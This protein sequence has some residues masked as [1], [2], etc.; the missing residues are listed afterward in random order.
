MKEGTFKKNSLQLNYVEGPNNGSPILLLHGAT[1]RWQSYE[2]IIDELISHFHLFLMDFRGHG[3]SQ[4]VHGKYTLEHYVE[5]TKYFIKNHIKKPTILVGH[6]LGG[7]VSI[8]LAALHPELVKALI[9]IDAPLTLHSLRGL[10]SNLKAHANQLIQ[11]LKLSQLFPDIN[12]FIPEH[13]RACDPDMLAAMVHRFEDT[14][15]NYNIETLMEKI[16]C[17]TLLIYGNAQRGSLIN[18][19]DIEQILEIKP[20]LVH[21]QISQAGHSPIRQDKE[22]TLKAIKEFIKSEQL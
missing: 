22:S 18:Y 2:P 14:F 15:K 20:D 10:I 17:P 11:G 1:K 5:D 16:Q 7:M 8:M 4:K 19:N 12:P 6:S 21:V 3:K 13:I 9:I